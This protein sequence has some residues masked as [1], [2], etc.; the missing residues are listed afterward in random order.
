[1]FQ[2]YAFYFVKWI[3]WCLCFSA[4][5]FFIYDLTCLHRKW[6]A[7]HGWERERAGRHTGQE[8]RR[9]E[10]EET[11]EDRTGVA[12]K[13]GSADAAPVT[14][15]RR[16]IQI[17]VKGICAQIKYQQSQFG[18]RGQISLFDI[19]RNILRVEFARQGEN[20]SNNLSPLLGVVTWQY[21]LDLGRR[22]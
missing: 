16:E 5:L 4:A 18:I 3:Y 19:W 1:M 10:E 17:E 13:Q 7:R 20:F 2:S 8:E 22:W 15:A 14:E 12:S 6:S 21:D 11:G 9:G